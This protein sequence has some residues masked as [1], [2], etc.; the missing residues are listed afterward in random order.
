MNLAML[1]KYTYFKSMSN[2]WYWYVFLIIFPLI[3]LFLGLPGCAPKKKFI[4]PPPKPRMPADTFLYFHM[5]LKQGGRKIPFRNRTAKIKP[6]PFSI[7][8]YLTEP[9]GIYLNCYPT[10]TSYSAARQEGLLDSIPG[11]TESS[12]PDIRNNLQKKILVA[13]TSPNYWYYKNDHDHSFNRVKKW[14]NGVIELERIVEKAELADSHAKM[15]AASRS[16]IPGTKFL[17]LDR[18]NELYLVACQV[19][20]DS[21]MMRTETKR[22]L[23]RIIFPGSRGSGKVL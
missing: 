9:G 17:K 23:F 19:N 20:V 6:A 2:R 15:W 5:V 21:D 12:L 16:A 1:Y 18:F 10:N 14:P 3:L 22:L 8:V 11:F 13:L 4:P 7:I